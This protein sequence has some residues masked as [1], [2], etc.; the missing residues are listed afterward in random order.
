MS[1]GWSAQ[2][3]PVSD[4]RPPG[5]SADG[6]RFGRERAWV[7]RRSRRSYGS[8]S[9]AKARGRKTGRG[10]AGWDCPLGLLLQAD[11]PHQLGA[12]VVQVLADL[13]LDAVGTA[14]QL[15]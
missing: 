3:N 9:T 7:C 12:E 13:D 4:Q 10:L 14:A 11:R 15:L 5:A 2:E 8:H 6:A 1:S